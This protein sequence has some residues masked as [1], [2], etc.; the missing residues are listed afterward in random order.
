MKI[1]LVSSFFPYPLFSGGQVRLY[2]LLRHLGKIHQIT[3]VCETRRN[4]TQKEREEIR[5]YC[6]KIIT[7]NRPKQWSVSNILKTGFSFFPF[8]LI[9][10]K[11]QQMKKIL[12]EEL[13]T[14]QYDLVHVETFYVM[15]NIPQTTV[16]KVLV[17]HN[18]EYDIYL[19]WVKNFK[20]F[21]FKPLLLIDILKIKYWEEFYWKKADLL[22][23]V[24]SDEQIIMEKEIGKKV[25]LV[26]NGV[27]CDYF[28]QVSKKEPK[29][30]TIVFVG[31]FNW[32]QNIDACL[33]LVKRLW[34]RI[35]KEYG[36]PVKLRL[37]GN[38]ILRKIGKISDPD[39]IIEESVADIRKVYA[40]STL[41]LAPIR[42]GGGTKFKILESLASGL[43][44]VTTKK[45]V[46]GLGSDTNGILVSNS[47]D[48]LIK[49]TVSL[50]QRDASREEIAKKE[51]VFVKENFDWIHIASHLDDL[52]QKS[53]IGH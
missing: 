53:A 8:L 49:T 28:S 29:I 37:V 18:L 36:L 24:S 35:K 42:I 5:K 45:G 46:E 44:I 32:I 6:Q 30:S 12:Q 7:V 39:I 34:P 31:S 25:E 19:R 16:P 4:L 41:L 11:N 26:P 21:V 14:Q 2:N 52:Y 17:E 43:P 13:S 1:L 51:R 15:Q 48:E 10:H 50:L 27:D 23:A 3:L 22:V 38:S 20:F 47:E 33:Y 9:G 40:N